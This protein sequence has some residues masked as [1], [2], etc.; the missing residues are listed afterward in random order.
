MADN[1]IKCSE[2]IHDFMSSR[3]VAAYCPFMLR[4][5]SFTQDNV[6]TTYVRKSGNIYGPSNKIVCTA[7]IELLNENEKA[8]ELTVTSH[9]SSVRSATIKAGTGS[10]D[11]R[12]F[13]TH[14]SSNG[15]Q[16][17]RE[18]K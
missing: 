11:S 9:H 7:Q 5:G 13:L 8:A 10:S 16:L 4:D 1:T 2:L 3:Y 17:W 12:Y 15:S 14:E 6:T 18:I